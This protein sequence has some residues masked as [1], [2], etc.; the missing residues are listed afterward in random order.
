MPSVLGSLATLVAISVA[1]F[2]IYY[3]LLLKDILTGAGYWRIVEPLNNAHCTI[4]PDLQ[5]C[6]S[7]FGCYKAF[8]LCLIF[9]LHRKRS[10]STFWPSVLCLL[11]SNKSGSLGTFC[12]LFQCVCQVSHRP[13][14]D[15]QS[16]DI[17]S[18]PSQNHRLS[19]FRTFGSPWL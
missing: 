6:E 18:H 19:L 7:A 4:V 2:G 17:K 10:P 15:I 9:L 1:L 3:Q 14:R 5:A 11:Y 12:R 8:Q 13:R 16:R